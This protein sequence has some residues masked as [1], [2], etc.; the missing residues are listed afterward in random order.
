MKKTNTYFTLDIREKKIYGSERSFKLANK[1]SGE[2]Y[3]QLMG[4]MN[5]HPNYEL[6]ETKAKS[7]DSKETYH[8]LNY[9]FMRDYIS[10]EGDAELLLKKLEKVIEAAKKTRA[11]A[12]PVVK[13][14][15][16]RTFGESVG[17]DEYKFDFEE[18]KARIAKADDES[19]FAAADAIEEATDNAENIAA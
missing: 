3:E 16:L 14:W 11:S 5:A 13:R 18:A 10:L 17:S 15:F 4:L 12:Y 2:A 7:N 19:I 8:G 6:E 9:Q 1:G